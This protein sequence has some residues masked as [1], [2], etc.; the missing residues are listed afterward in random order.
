MH[1]R[2]LVL[3]VFAVVVG[4]LMFA[5]A[6]AFAA[7]EAP[8]TSPVSGVTATSA[9][10]GGTLNPGASGKAGWYFF[11]STEIS[12]LVGQTAT[13][14]EPE[15]EGQALAEHVEVTGL[16]PSK[17][18]RVCMVA[19]N[20]AGEATPSANEASFTTPAAPPTVEGET[21]SDVTSTVATLEGQVNP[22]NQVTSC[23]IQYGTTTSYGTNAP[24]EQ[25][26]LEGYGDQRVALPQLT[27]LT[28]GTTYHF[29]IVAENASKAKKDGPDQAFTT[30][31]TPNTDL[32]SAITPRTATLN[33]HLTLNP[34]D[35]QYHFLY[36]IGTE[37]TGETETPTEDAGSG[38]GTPASSA[39]PVT[40][41]IPATQYTV[42]LVDSNAFGSEQG[43]A[44]SF[45]TPAAE[46]TVSQES[47][48][49]VTA[50]SAEFRAEVDPGGAATTYHFDYGTTT[51][52]GQS[53][54]ESSPVG[55]DNS[56]HPTFRRYPGATTR[57]HI[58]LQA[59]SDQRTKSCRWNA[60]LRSNVHDPDYWWGVRTTRQSR[61]R[62]RLPA[63]E[64]RSGS[65]GD[66]WRRRDARRRRCD[67]SIRRRHESDVRSERSG[68]LEPARE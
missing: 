24:C 39:T 53:T 54:P 26:S 28:P 56:N 1:A 30:V 27:G 47:V 32:V 9:T 31:P 2:R 57:H 15:V 22:N 10:L 41:L 60:R 25:Q 40:G 23:E 51:S 33:G 38:P 50:T 43:P 16:Q 4:V 11:Y 66:R 37:C 17:T 3:S 48:T 55:S 5:S 61:L 36:K 58:S 52:Y 7:P 14:Q 63:T 35:T 68:W 29:R 67:A 8:V 65:Y 62:T 59:R 12:C 45:T 64:G 6:P 19:T 21:A 13:G 18:Y 49:E 44:V 42:C 34:V 46:P 20:E